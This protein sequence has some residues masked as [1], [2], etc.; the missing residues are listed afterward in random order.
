[1]S[2][3]SKFQLSLFF[4]FGQLIESD[5][6]VSQLDS[7]ENCSDGGMS[8][9]NFNT[10]KK[11]PIATIEPPPEF[12]DSPQTTLL[13]APH[14]QTFANHV[15]KKILTNAITCYTFLPKFEIRKRILDEE[16]QR[17]EDGNYFVTKPEHIYNENI[18][19]TQ[20]VSAFVLT[21]S[22]TMKKQ[23]VEEEEPTYDV[24]ANYE[25]DDDGNV[26]AGGAVWQSEKTSSTQ[27]SK[28]FEGAT[29]EI[30]DYDL[31]YNLKPTS[32]FDRRRSP[33][34]SSVLY[35]PHCQSTHNSNSSSSHHHHHNFHQLSYHHQCYHYHQNSS[36]L[37]TANRPNSRNSLNS[38][39][40]SSHNSL[41]VTTTNKVDDSIFITQAMSHDA[42]MGHEISDFYNVPFDSDMYSLPVDMLKTN[43][44]YDQPANFKTSAFSLIKNHRIAASSFS[45]FDKIDKIKIN[46]GKGQ[47]HH[48]HC[49]KLKNSRNVKKRKRSSN[50]NNNNN[51]N[52]NTNNN[53][54]DIYDTEKNAGLHCK[55]AGI[56]HNNNNNNNLNINNN[57]N[58]NNLDKSTTKST[59]SSKNY[60]STTL[61]SE[62]H[63]FY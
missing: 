63:I 60:S 24:P 31:Y 9:E 26:A 12:Q 18:Y 42:L 56:S 32:S 3:I 36:N 58:N 57:I 22:R 50:N 29:S 13:R 30:Y 14:I 27:R 59:K 54:N 23:V 61:V 2:V 49:M 34:S 7:L 6:E 19:D 48:H 45:S 4:F 44:I 10:L 35:S 38:R 51:N 43:K 55:N 33:P 15:A 16:A 46:N 40:S 37:S 20:A 17:D 8:A 53:N 1:M 21:K 62:K 5:A 25:E 52:I 39:L 47:Q 11:V 41:N 28:L